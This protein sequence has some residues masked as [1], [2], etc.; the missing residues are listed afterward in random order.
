MSKIPLTTMD[1]YPLYLRV[2]HM[3]K[4]RG[5]QRVMSYDIA[6]EM[7]VDAATVRRDFS[8]LGRLGRQGYGYDVDALIQRFTQ[9]MKVEGNTDIVLFGVGNMGHALLKYN[10]FLNK[11]GNI[12]CAFE[13]DW[14]KIGGTVEGVP[15]Y[16]LSDLPTKF[17][18]GVQIAIMAI[19]GAYLQD[20]VDE[21]IS[22]GVRAFINFSD[23]DIRARKKIIVQKIDLVALIQDVVYRFKQA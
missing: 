5:I 9:E 2:F 18:M 20:L 16:H 22:L 15:I 13:T 23:G 7:D 12:I 6:R 17:P 21:L 11:T 8:Y 19:P 10:S 3:L 1:R 14:A 4:N